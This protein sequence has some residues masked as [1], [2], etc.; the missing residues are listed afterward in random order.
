MFRKRRKGGG[1]FLPGLLSPEVEGA[2]HK[3]KMDSPH[4]DQ[5]RT[6]EMC[7]LSIVASG[8]E[9][10]EGEAQREMEPSS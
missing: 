7:A 10:G 6:S 4:A 2:F 9:K 1:G 3:G 5:L 8:V